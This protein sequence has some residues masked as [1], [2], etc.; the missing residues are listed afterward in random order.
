[1]SKITEKDGYYAYGVLHKSKRYTDWEVSGGEK[2]SKYRSEWG[3]RAAEADP[4]P[5]PLNLN[6]EVTTKCNLACG[7][8]SHKDLKDYQ[9]YDMDLDLFGQVLR[10]AYDFEPSLGIP[11]VNLNGLGEPLLNPEFFSFIDICKKI[12]VIDIFFHTN[13]TVLTDTLIDKLVNSGVHRVVVSVDSP[14]KETYEEMRVLRSSYLQSLQDGNRQ[15]AGYSHDKLIA[16]MKKLIDKSHSGN[17]PLIRTTTVL[18]DQTYKQL[19]VFKQLW[20]NLGA[21]LITFQDLTN[22]S[23]DSTGWSSTA[24]SIDDDYMNAIK[25]DIVEKKIPFTCPYIFQSA[26]YSINGDMRACTNPNAREEM[27]MGS[28][29]EHTLQEIWNNPKYTEL[30]DLH[31]EGRWYDHPICVNC[32]LPAVELAKK[33]YSW[34]S[35]LEVHQEEELKESVS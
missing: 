8:C 4:G 24:T 20:L 31:R 19:E 2:Y 27:V 25:K 17:T 12:G 29:K 35:Q 9:I 10:S 18:T 13:G 5:L 32:Q 11:A 7:F 1:M 30:R 21:D 16:N 22:D 28:L 15:L 23:K 34:K 14:V 6:V 3:R 33:H 26:I